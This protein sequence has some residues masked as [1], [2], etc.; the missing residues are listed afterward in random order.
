MVK[1]MVKGGWEFHNGLHETRTNAGACMTHE[2]Y[3]DT[4]LKHSNVGGC[5]DRPLLN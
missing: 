4:E 3:V 2:P 1:P 5:Y